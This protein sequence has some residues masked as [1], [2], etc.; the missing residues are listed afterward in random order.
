MDTESLAII[1]VI[2]TYAGRKTIK[3][4]FKK[5]KKKKSWA[6]FTRVMPALWEDCLSYIVSVVPATWPDRK[7]GGVKVG[8]ELELSPGDGSGRP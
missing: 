7:L 4:Y 1:E 8:R 3:Y 6:R 5:K 2:K